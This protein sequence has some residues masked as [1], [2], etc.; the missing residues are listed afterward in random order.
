MWLCRLANSVAHDIHKL[1]FRGTVSNGDV[2]VEQTK[3]GHSPPIWFV[4]SGTLSCAAAAPAQD[5]SMKFWE[6][7]LS[8]ARA[9]MHCRSKNNPFDL[10]TSP[11]AVLHNI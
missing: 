8:N 9:G 11:P 6:G 10:L 2:K 3:M 5:E 4:F 7:A 1:P